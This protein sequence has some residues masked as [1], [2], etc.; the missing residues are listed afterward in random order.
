MKLQFGQQRSQKAVTQL[1]VPSWVPPAYIIPLIDRRK[2]KQEPDRRPQPTVED[3][4]DEETWRRYEEWQRKQERKPPED[5][6]ER[7]VFEIRL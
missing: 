6:P 7:G 3:G 2:Q 4:A 1:P 5:S